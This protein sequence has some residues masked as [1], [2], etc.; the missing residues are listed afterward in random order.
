M[1]TPRSRSAQTPQC[2]GE[3]LSHPALWVQNPHQGR[4]LALHQSLSNSAALG[5]VQTGQRHCG[6]F[7]KKVE[8]NLPRVERL[9]VIYRSN[10]DT[11]ACFTN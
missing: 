6:F 7:E 10:Q 4:P 8:K 2:T 1:S 3:L 5:P 11:T 9:S